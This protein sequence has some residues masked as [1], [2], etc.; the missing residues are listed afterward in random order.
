MS[1]FLAE[2]ANFLF[3]RPRIAR[4]VAHELDKDEPYKR[5]MFAA[6]WI[7][8]VNVS[9]KTALVRHLEAA[10]VDGSTILTRAEKPEY[11]QR[12][13]SNTQAAAD[14]GAFGS[15]TF[16]VGGDLFFGNDR[17]DFLEA[18]LKERPS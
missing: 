3:E 1:P 13:E 18:K 6:F 10:G 15:P 11:A 14:R 4:L 8:A 17:L 2:R 7:D 5:A 16:I 12:L 9:D